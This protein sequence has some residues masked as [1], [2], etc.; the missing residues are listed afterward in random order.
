LAATCLISLGV[1]LIVLLAM[2]RRGLRSDG[3]E[4]WRGRVCALATPARLLSAL[5]ISLGVWTMQVAT[6]ALV[7]RATNIA[8]PLAGSL[9]AMLLADTGLLLRAT[10][11]NVGFFQFAYQIAAQQYGVPNDA[12][13]AT[14][15]LLQIIQAVPITVAA[16]ALTPGFMKSRALLDAREE[17]SYRRGTPVLHGQITAG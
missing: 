3:G 2:S 5:A 11:G 17:R 4:S 7:A 6:F 14:A 9:A 10:P 13:I 12:A 16:L 1:V 15:L 8:L